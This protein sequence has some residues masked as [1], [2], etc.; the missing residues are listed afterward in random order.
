MRAVLKESTL[1]YTIN[2]SVLPTL[3]PSN[4]IPKKAVQVQKGLVRCVA[5]NAAE[6]ITP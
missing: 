5:G 6:T 4:S 2:C 1:L 3:F